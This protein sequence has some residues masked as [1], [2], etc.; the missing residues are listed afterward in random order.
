MTKNMQMTLVAHGALVFLAGM[1]AGFP[2]ASVLV[3]SLDPAATTMWPGDVRAWKMAHMEGALNGMLMIAVAA[4]MAHAAM[5]AGMQ[6]IIVWGLIVT[7]W[8]NIVASVVSAMT[9]GRGLG[10]TG[11]DWNSLTFTLFMLAIIGVVAAMMAVAVAA[12]R[13][14]N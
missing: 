10:F 6:K 13:N 9:G 5:G 1:L 8:G 12:F 2:F 3:A 4:A 14:R 7:G 11:L